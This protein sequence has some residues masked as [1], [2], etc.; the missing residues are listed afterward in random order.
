MTTAIYCWALAAFLFIS[1]LA[2]T[3]TDRVMNRPASVRSI[4]ALLLLLAIPCL[5][6]CGWFFWTLFAGLTLSGIWRLVFPHS[7]IRAQKNTYP[8][9]VHGCLLIGGPVLIWAL[10]PSS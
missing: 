2:P 10:K 4:G 1:A 5:V 8:R 6:W 7:S 9:W 3:Q